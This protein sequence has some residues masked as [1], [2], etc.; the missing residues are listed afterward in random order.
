[1]TYLDTHVVIWLYSYGTEAPLPESAIA[2]MRAT[3]DL[4]ISPMVRLEIEYLREIERIT[5]PA[6]QILA[7]LS[8][9][10]GLRLCDAPFAAVVQAAASLT[11]TRDPFDRIIVGQAALHGAPLVTRDGAIHEHYERALW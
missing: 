9:V 11:W 1:V 3:D 2:A 10:L 6:S 5:V 4:R 8:G 7:E